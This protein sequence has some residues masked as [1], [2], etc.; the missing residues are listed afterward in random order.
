MY[1][2][3][4]FIC[5]HDNN[6]KKNSISLNP[7]RTWFYMILWKKMVGSGSLGPPFLVKQLP[8]FSRKPP[9]PSHHFHLHGLWKAGWYRF[10]TVKGLG[11]SMFWVFSRNVC[12]NS[13]FFNFQSDENPDLTS[14]LCDNS[15]LDRDCSPACC[16]S[17]RSPAK[18]PVVHHQV[19]GNKQGGLW[20]YSTYR[21]DYRTGTLSRKNGN[22]S[23]L[24]TG[25]KFGEAM[26]SAKILVPCWKHGFS[27]GKNNES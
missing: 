17:D 4:C 14:N 13:K 2:Y 3:Y 8:G 20:I 21:S 6:H 11:M 27:S 9:E 19:L 16:D 22:E 25:S 18:K 10:S 1:N 24:I 26:F 23:L 12:W 7:H 15:A 5:N